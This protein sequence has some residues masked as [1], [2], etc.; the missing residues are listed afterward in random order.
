MTNLIPFPSTCVRRLAARLVSLTASRDTLSAPLVWRNRP[1]PPEQLGNMLQ[2]LARR[3]PVL[4][5]LVESIIAEALAQIDPAYPVH[6]SAS[7]S[8]S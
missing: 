1:T 6:P 2:H 8:S 5:L 3:R 4:V 7:E